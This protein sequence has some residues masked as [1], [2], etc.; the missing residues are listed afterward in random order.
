MKQRLL[1]TLLLLPFLLLACESEPAPEEEQPALQD[2]VM[3]VHDE[4]MAKMDAIY[5]TK[6][7]LQEQQAA[8]DSTKVELHEEIQARV[9]DLAAADEAMMSWMRNYKAPADPSTPE[10]QEY[11]Q[12]EMVKIEAVREQML[13]A[14]EASNQL[15]EELKTATDAE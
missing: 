1:L 9:A 11:L 13:T 2:R 6:K 12:E 15:L 7:A 8:L 3:A 10:A 5:Q 4:A 14:I